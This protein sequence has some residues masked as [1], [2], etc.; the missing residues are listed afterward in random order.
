MVDRCRTSISSFGGQP[1]KMPAPRATIHRN[2]QRKSREHNAPGPHLYLPPLS[3]GL[4]LYASRIPTHRAGRT[5]RTFCGAWRPHAVEVC[6]RTIISRPCRQPSHSGIVRHRLRH[7]LLMWRMW[8]GFSRRCWRVVYPG[9][10]N[11]GNQG[12]HMQHAPSRLWANNSMCVCSDAS[13]SRADA[14]SLYG[15]LRGCLQPNTSQS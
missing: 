12:R 5:R 8:G 7:R 4:P 6:L 1:D 14:C 13:M 10:F 9:R 3:C 2:S 11:E 15:T